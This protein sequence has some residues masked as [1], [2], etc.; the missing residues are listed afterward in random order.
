M[1]KFINAETGQ[2]IKSEHYLIILDSELWE[3]EFG[4]TDSA[5]NSQKIWNGEG[6]KVNVPFKIELCP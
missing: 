2:E 5:T 6:W 1:I 4:S 3:V